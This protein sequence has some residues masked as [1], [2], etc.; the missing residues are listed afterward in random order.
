MMMGG[1]SATMY[2]CEAFE[3]LEQFEIEFAEERA[4]RTAGQ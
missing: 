1:G 4:S 2:G 3:A